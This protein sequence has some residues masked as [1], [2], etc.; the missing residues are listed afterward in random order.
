[1]RKTTDIGEVRRLA[2]T[3]LMIEPSNTPYSPVIV[4]HP[5][6]NSGLC[7]IKTNNEHQMLD[8]TQKESNLLAWQKYISGIIDQS[9][10]TEIFNMFNPAYG[11]TFI[12][13]AE[14]FL[15]QKDLSEM[16]VQVWIQS[17]NP[18]NDANV[19]KQD[20]RRLFE[21][22]DPAILMDDSER[23]ELSQ[24]DDPV[25]VYRGVTQ[26][27]S[28]NIRAFSWTIDYDKAE[29]FAHRF[30]EEGTVYAAQIYKKHIFALFNSRNE[31][32]VILDPQYLRGIED[33]QIADTDIKLQ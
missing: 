23:K 30:N 29:W 9:N 16:L 2:R 15:S 21:R 32:E 7:V 22:S 14:P 4:Q 18:N 28:E 33:I 13:Y 5:F 19:S 31:A 27:N 25:T 3:F 1:M 17:E 10:L 6:T 12:K 11:L 8:I 24:L 20:I 26:Y